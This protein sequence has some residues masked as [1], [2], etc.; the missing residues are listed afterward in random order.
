VNEHDAGEGKLPT[1]NERLEFLGDAILDSVVAELLFLRFPYKKEG[2]LTEMR[3]RIVNREQMSYLA[4][5]LGLIQ[6]MEIK[7]ELLKNPVAAKSI[8]G[9]A[10]E[11][12][13]GAIY[14]DHGYRTVKK[15]ISDRLV[16]QYLDIDKLMETTVSYKAL[17]LK[18]AQ[19]NKKKVDWENRTESHGRRDLFVVTLI[20]DETKR[21]TEKNNSR[22][23]AEELCCE[24]ACR[25]L[26]IN[27]EKV[28]FP[29][30]FHAGLSAVLGKLAPLTI[31]VAAAF[32][33][34]KRFKFSVSFFKQRGEEIVIVLTVGL[35]KYRKMALVVFVE[36]IDECHA[37]NPVFIG[38]PT[39]NIEVAVCLR[40]NFWVLEV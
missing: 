31:F 21:F 40:P 20:L 13:I 29:G 24:K 35:L 10:M 25:L 14:L 37:A 12:L 26:E 11:A 28:L 17:L 32:K 34:F 30:N 7:P 1:D 15:F 19:Q 22:K 4:S 27:S 8:A 39:Y 16:G 9:N 36:R 23:R 33:K 2:F 3:M 5:R 38:L 18:W 6:M